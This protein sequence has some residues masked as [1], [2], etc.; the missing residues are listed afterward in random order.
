MAPRFH[1]D[2]NMLISL[3]LLG[4]VSGCTAVGMAVDVAEL[5]LITSNPDSMQNE[6]RHNYYEPTILSSTGDMIRIK[7][8]DVNSNA[9]HEEAL[10]L[11]SKNCGGSYI[12]ISRVNEEGWTT[13]EAE[14]THDTDS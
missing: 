6:P 14:C 12:E 11:M 8:L 1:N 9:Q 7:Y 10:Q 4:S 13:V 5:A 3:V 2:S